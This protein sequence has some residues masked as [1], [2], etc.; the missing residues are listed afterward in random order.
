MVWMRPTTSF[1]PAG[2]STTPLSAVRTVRR[3]DHSC[4]SSRRVRFRARCMSRFRARFR[5]RIMRRIRRRARMSRRA[6]MG[7]RVRFSRRRWLCINQVHQATMGLAPPVAVG[8]ARPTCI[9]VGPATIPCR[10]V[11]LEEAPG[12]HIFNRQ[13]VSIQAR[14][15]CRPCRTIHGVGLVD[16]DSLELLVLGVLPPMEPTI[17]S[18][19]NV[20]GLALAAMSVF[21]STQRRMMEVSRRPSRQSRRKR[22]GERARRTM[23]K[24]A[25]ARKMARTRISRRRKRNDNSKT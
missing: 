25:R 6:N 13:L 12:M 1:T 22:R 20:L 3:R 4:R 10:M 18:T 7:I 21:I 19:R 2:C 5:A 9:R 15:H 8:M 14:G 23:A 17:I 24:R 16:T 11:P